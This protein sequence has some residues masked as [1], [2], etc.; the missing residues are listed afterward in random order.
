MAADSPRV[1]PSRLRPLA[2]SSNAGHPLPLPAQFP[3]LHHT[4]LL[5][6]TL[7]LSLSCPLL[8]HEPISTRLTWQN[9]IRPIFEQRCLACHHAGASLPLAS[10]A[11]ARPWAVAI[12]E[13]VLART[14]PPWP[15]VKGFGGPFAHDPTLSTEEIRRITDWVLG[16][17]P[18]KPAPT[19]NPPTSINPPA[20]TPATTSQPR[21]PPP[22]PRPLQGPP[23]PS[24]AT[25]R[26]QTARP[27]TPLPAG[28]LWAIALPAPPRN[29]PRNPLRPAQ[30]V[31]LF[32]DHQPLVWVEPA[33]LTPS[34]PRLLWLASPLTLRP[35][36]RL[37]GT[38]TV[39][40]HYRPLP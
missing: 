4:H 36:S 31:K 19:S 34:A 2:P 32:L 10:Y 7:L 16:G 8:A 26:Q 33:L 38:G 27:G 3:A 12:K 5:L 23:R 9:E 6:L 11:Q 37:A 35:T 30:P 13:M 40:L 15:A 21:T 28:Q 18:E 1:T 20:A 24:L 25:L 22:S 29:P 17:A 39:I 14:M